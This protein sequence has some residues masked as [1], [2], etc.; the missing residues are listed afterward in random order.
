MEI[1]SE[2]HKKPFKWCARDKIVFYVTLVAFS[3]TIATAVILIKNN[4]TQ[5]QHYELL[6]FFLSMCYSPRYTLLEHFQEIVISIVIL[7]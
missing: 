1:T 4:K 7:D 6:V 2:K 5:K 3:I